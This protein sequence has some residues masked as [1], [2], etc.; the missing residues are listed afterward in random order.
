MLIINK[1]LIF[2]HLIE[3]T[4]VL[5]KGIDV[6]SVGCGMIFFVRFYG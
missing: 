5:Y 4:L 6:A 1:I 2:G 3:K